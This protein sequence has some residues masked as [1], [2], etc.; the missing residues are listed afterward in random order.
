[1]KPTTEYSVRT[2]AATLDAHRDRLDELHRAHA[3]LTWPDAECDVADWSAIVGQIDELG[4]ASAGLSVALTSTMLPTLKA[5]KTIAIQHR[6]EVDQLDQAF[7]LAFP[8][9]RTPGA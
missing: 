7:A 2:I 9:P 6:A 1:M 8:A 4:Q 3:A 5:L